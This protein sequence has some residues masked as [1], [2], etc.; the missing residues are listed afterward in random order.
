MN[1]STLSG[2]HVELRGVDVMEIT[3]GTV[4]SNTIYYDGA[5]FA[6]QVG[7][8]PRQGSVADKALVSVFN[9]KTRAGGRHMP[10]G[11]AEVLDKTATP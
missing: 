10:G 7:H 9:A 11:L 2:R 5:S 1:E 6:R 8:L 3:D 4:R